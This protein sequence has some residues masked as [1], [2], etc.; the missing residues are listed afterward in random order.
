MKAMVTGSTGFVGKRLIKRLKKEKVTVV[1]FSRTKYGD[2]IS[3]LDKLLQKSKG[4]DFVFHLAA[5]L[6]ED[7][8]LSHLRQV[9]V[10]GTKKVWAAARQ[11]KCDKFIFLSSTGVYGRFDDQAHEMYPYNPTTNYEHSKK[12]AEE[13][14]K[15]NDQEL[16]SVIVRSA[17][18]M[19]PNTYWKQIIKTIQKG[20]PIIGTGHNH[21]QIVYV[22]DLVDALVFLAKNKK[23]IGVFN[24]AEEPSQART[25]KQLVEL[26]LSEL[27][28]KT[29]TQHIPVW[30]GKGFAHG[31]TLMA[32][33]Q[34]KKT[35]LRP[36]YVDRLLKN[37]HYSIDKIKALGWKPRFGT[38]ESVKK[39]IQELKIN[40]QG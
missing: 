38:E 15:A 1:E 17:L 10:E 5:E 24:V 16:R 12:E 36:E 6:E 27:Q 40:S 22:D 9:N 31:A 28:L 37:R 4:C 39:T 18:V 2:D 3:D 13:F 21:W 23:G 19:G 34:G 11:N 25:L 20:F 8:P 29:K 7:K 32:M 35:I 30:I 26:I 14:V 33:L